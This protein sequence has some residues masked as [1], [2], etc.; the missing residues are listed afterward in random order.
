MDFVVRDRRLFTAFII[1]LGALDCSSIAILTKTYASVV[2]RDTLRIALT[3]A[4]LNDLEVKASNSDVQNVL[5]FFFVIIIC[6]RSVDRFTNFASSSAG[7]SQVRAS[8]SQRTD[9][10]DSN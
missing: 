10:M 8:D 3:L 6:E 1:L 2:S 5:D 9:E 4:A 7:R